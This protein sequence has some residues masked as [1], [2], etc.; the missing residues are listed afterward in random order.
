M[1][2]TPVGAVNPSHLL[3]PPAGAPLKKRRTRP[4]V[5]AVPNSFEK[6]ALTFCRQQPPFHAS[7]P[8]TRRRQNSSIGPHDGVSRNGMP[9]YRARR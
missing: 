2:E 9:R 1:K 3:V 5:S 7:I 6:K 8:Q 4:P